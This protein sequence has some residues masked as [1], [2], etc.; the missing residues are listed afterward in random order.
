MA[1]VLGILKAGAA[2]VPLDPELPAQRIAYMMQDSGLRVVLTHEHLLAKM[3]VVAGVKALLVEQVLSAGVD[4]DAEGSACVQSDGAVAADEG[5]S[6]GSRLDDK[7]ARD[8]VSRVAENSLPE[9]HGS[10]LAYVIY[11]SG[12]T[13][14][15][16]GVGVSHRSLASCMQ[17]MQRVYALGDDDTVL[18]KA[19]IGSMCRA[20]KCSGL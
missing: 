16:K 12:S 7:V 20:G 15:P 5:A 13:G 17:W 11:T 8:H 19:P 6:S 3:P 4:V 18:L 9:I 14:M 2:F 10:Q 1:S